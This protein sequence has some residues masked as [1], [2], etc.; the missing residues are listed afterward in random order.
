MKK[1]IGIVFILVILLLMNISFADDV[2]PDMDIGS[3]YEEE[4]EA[5]S[6]S[7]DEPEILSRSA[8]IFDRN[9]KQVLWGKQENL[10]VPQASTTN[11][12]SYKR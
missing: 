7:A 1:I 10:R 5:V 2:D 11:V 3:I 9:S 12:V 4:L 8:V 6:K